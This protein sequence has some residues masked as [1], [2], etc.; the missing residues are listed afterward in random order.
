MTVKPNRTGTYQF[1]VDMS[2]EE[3]MKSVQ[4]FRKKFYGTSKYVKLQGRWGK[5]NPNYTP[6]KSAWGGSQ[7]FVPL[8]K[9]AYADVY[10][11]DRY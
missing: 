3:D 7:Y 8:S 4:N 10:V 5:N 6:S 2:C 11:Y 1:T 9:A